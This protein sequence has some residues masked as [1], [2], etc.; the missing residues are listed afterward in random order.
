[1]SWESREGI[2]I[3]V[4]VEELFLDRGDIS[5][6]HTGEKESGMGAAIV[7]LGNQAQLY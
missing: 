2:E 6:I 4:P 5:A 7:G 1:M 3:K